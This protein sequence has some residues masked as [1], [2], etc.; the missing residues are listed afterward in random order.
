MTFR[1]VFRIRIRMIHMFLGLPDPHP[2]PLVRDVDPD[3]G[4]SYCF[5]TSLLPYFLLLK[6]YVNVPSKSKK[7]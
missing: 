3:P 5:V 6:N 2:D 7:Q 1:A 4:D